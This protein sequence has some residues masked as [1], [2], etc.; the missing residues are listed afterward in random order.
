MA[1]DN[2]KKKSRSGFSSTKAGGYAAQ[3]RYREN[4]PDRVREQKRKQ[5]QKNKGSIYEPKLRIPAENKPLL[6]NLLTSTGLSITQL[7]LGAI[8][9]KYGVK[10]SK[11][12]DKNDSQ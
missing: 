3:K 8:E 12:I 1:D 4:H 7:C 9:E 11:P 2:G 6:E 10:L 5:N